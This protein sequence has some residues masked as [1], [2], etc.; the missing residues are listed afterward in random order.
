MTLTTEPEDIK[1][2]IGPEDGDELEPVQP[3][4]VNPFVPMPRWAILSVLLFGAFYALIV[5]SVAL[6]NVRESGDSMVWVALS[7][8]WL[9]VWIFYPFIAYHPAYGWCHPLILPALLSIINLLPRSTGLFMNGLE[10]HSML[11]GWSQQELNMVYAYGNCVNSLA[12][13]ATYAGFFMGPRFGVPALQPPSAAPRRL[14]TVLLLFLGISV[15]TFFYYAHLYG[16]FSSQLKSLAFGMAKRIEMADD[17]DGIGHYTALMNMATIAAIVWVCAQASALRNPFF[18]LLGTGSLALAYLCDGK[19]SS[20]IYPAILILLCWMV[21]NRKVPYL[22]LAVVGTTAFFLIGLLGLVRSSNWTDMNTLNLDAF[23][24]TSISEMGT[25]SLEEMAKRSGS[26]STFF[27]ILA[28]VPQEEDMLYGKTYLEWGLRFVPRQLWPEKPRGVDVQANQTFYG[29]DWGLPAGAVGEAYWNFHLPGVLIIFFLMGIFKRWLADLL[30]NYPTAPAVMVIYMLS[31]F[32]F[33]PSQNGFKNWLYAI[34]P[35][36][37][38]L[39][40]GGL[41]GLR[42][43]TSDPRLNSISIHRRA[44]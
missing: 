31:L 23:H 40:L 4:A 19:R 30:L 6:N 5:C 41:L 14:Y 38:M 13:I 29:A 27:A 22:R 37:C 25:K 39:T 44:A 8:V 12:L 9:L 33:D 18:W 1:P 15:I 11:P 21:R 32:Y 42:R 3:E 10:E 36:L 35:A 7:T 28:K 43:S 26:E 24:E 34:I 20:F 16:G 2:K 17:V